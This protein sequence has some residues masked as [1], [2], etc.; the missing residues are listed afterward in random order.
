MC[1]VPGVMA[2]AAL[3]SAA[4]SAAGMVQQGQ[5]QRRQ[6]GYQTAMAEANAAAAEQ[7]AQAQDRAAERAVEQGQVAEQRQRLLTAQAISGQR[8]ALAAA[9]VQ[10][11]S[12]SALDLTADTAQV[13]E[14]DALSR[15]QSAEEDAYQHRWQAYQARTNAN[16]ALAQGTL[17]GMRGDAAVTGSLFSAGGSLLNR[18]PAVSRGFGK[19][20][21]PEDGS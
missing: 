16:A 20:W 4:V 15:R 5:A 17:A 12:G 13:G 21:L 11:D 3:A 14:L 19:A 10:V 9:G 1:A 8:A 2:A 18:I 6:A 7:A